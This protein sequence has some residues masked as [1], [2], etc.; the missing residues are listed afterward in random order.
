MENSSQLKW[1]FIPLSI[2]KPQSEGTGMAMTLITLLIGYY[3]GNELF[4]KMAIP[5]IVITMTVPKLFYPLAVVWFSISNLL[6]K[7]MPKVLL[8]F[9]Y[10]V[11]LLPV[12]FARRLF[13]YDALLLRQWKKS[14]TSVMKQRQHSYVSADLDKPY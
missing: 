2:T 13:G 8:T 9:V 11:V 3:T 6:S 10:L 4:Y 14:T 7:V 12:G 1:G 5:A